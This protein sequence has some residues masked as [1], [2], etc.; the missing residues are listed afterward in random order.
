MIARHA[1]SGSRRRGFGLAI[2]V[3]ALCAIAILAPLGVLGALQQGALMM[4]P[5]LLLAVVL[6][7]GRY[8]GERLIARW[9]RVRP[10][11]RRAAG[12]A[13]TPAHPALQVPR[14]GRLIAG[15]LAGRAPPVLAA[16]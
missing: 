4:L 16:G 10:R 15:S 2:V 3:I 7:T 14:G 12:R 11:A 8:P 13:C 9:A 5:A 6:L 1:L